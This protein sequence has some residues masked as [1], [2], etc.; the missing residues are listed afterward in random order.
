MVEGRHVHIQ[1]AALL[2]TEIGNERQLVSFPRKPK[3]GSAK[4]GSA[5]SPGAL[6]NLCGRQRVLSQRMAIAWGLVGRNIAL[7]KSRVKL[8]Q[9]EIQFE[10]NLN[11]LNRLDLPN[12]LADR[13]TILKDAWQLYRQ[14]LF[15]AEP[16]LPSAR[17]VLDL[18]EEILLATD[19]LTYEAE[20]L[21]AT[22]AARFVNIAGRN[23]MLSQRIGKLFL[24][25]EWGLGGQLVLQRLETSRIEFECNLAEL[26]RS[27]KGIPELAAQLDEVDGQWRKFESMLIPSLANIGKARYALTALAAGERLFRH[28]DTA[29]KLY[30]RLAD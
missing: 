22:P 13:L 4:E 20:K 19:R 11:Q 18:S 2:N 30:E 9:L 15:D 28:A 27:G 10:R 16:A 17:A 14:A 12:V 23:R 24:F 26:Q 5:I 1:N 21:S 6:I 25:R 7:V 3:H 29:V 8:R